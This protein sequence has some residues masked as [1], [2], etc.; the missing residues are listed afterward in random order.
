MATWPE[1]NPKP[2]YPLTITPEFGTLVSNFDGGGEA[3]RQKLLYPR[4]NVV[5][6]YDMISKIE[7]QNLWDFYMARKGS[8]E[9]FY[10]YDLT[11]L[12]PHSFSH[13]E[14]YCGTGDGTTTIFDIPGRSTSSQIIYRDNVNETANTTILYGGGESNSDRV[15]FDIFAPETGLII[16]ANFV[17]YLR[18][19]VR[20]AEDNLSRENFVTNLYSYNIQLKG[21][22]AA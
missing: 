2:R 3:R 5:V 12:I 6:D 13:T 20:F 15:R 4:Y 22:S 10:I 8:Y 16:T 14:Q 1:S 17:G 19:K 18:M 7:A 9:A 21:L 11:L